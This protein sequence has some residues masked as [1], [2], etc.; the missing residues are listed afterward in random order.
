[1]VLRIQDLGFRVEGSGLMIGGC[2]SAP[3]YLTSEKGDEEMPGFG[4]YS[5]ITFREELMHPL[6]IMPTHAVAENLA[7]LVA[8]F[9]QS[10]FSVTNVSTCQSV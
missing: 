6:C 2:G 9:S 10:M 3:A 1:M 5:F 4:R 8:R 7:Q